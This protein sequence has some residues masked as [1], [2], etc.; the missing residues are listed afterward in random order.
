MKSIIRT[1][2]RST[3]AAASKQPKA[4]TELT[5]IQS[6]F[7][8]RKAHLAV[9]LGLIAPL[10]SFATSSSEAPY[11]I[12][13]GGGFGN[14]GTT[15]V[16]RNYSQPDAGKCSPWTGYTKT[17]DTVILITNGTACMASDSKA[18]TVSVTS[19]DPS[20]FPINQLTADYIQLTR[21]SSSDSFSGQDYGA[22]SGNAAPTT[23]TDSLLN[24]PSVH[25]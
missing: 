8:F 6:G 5:K 7:R 17:A 2:D 23:C 4:S 24:L 15:F 13:V 16:A 9:L 18:L 19:A 10:P 14:G 12:A 22:F 21:D 20:F 11:C 3:G 25:D 1:F